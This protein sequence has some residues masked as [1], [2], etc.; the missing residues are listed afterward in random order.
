MGGY[1]GGYPALQIKP[2]ES[3]VQQLG[4]IMQLRNM[5]GQQQLQQQQIQSAQTQ[6]QSQQLDLQMKQLALKNMQTTQTALSDP[7][8]ADDFGK[9]NQSKGSPE[10]MTPAATAPGAA[11]SSGM[12]VEL[13]PIAQFLM[14]KKGLPLFGPGGAMEISNNLT[15]AA[16]DVAT[17]VKTKGDIATTQLSNYGKQLDNLTDRAEPV[18]STE[19]PAQQQAALNVFKQQVKMAPL[20]FP[21]ELVKRI[22][23]IKT[24]ADLAPMVNYGKMH[25][26]IIKEGTAQAEE[27]TAKANAVQKT[28][29]ASGIMDKTGAYT[30][31]AKS[32]MDTVNNYAAI[33]APL[34]TGLVKQMQN[35]PDMETLQKI[36]AWANSAQESFQRSADSLN[37][38]RAMKDVSVG[39]AMATE[40]IKQ[41]QTLQT[42]LQ[43]SANIRGQLDMSQGGNQQATQ[44]A[45]ISFAGHELRAGGVNRITQPEINTLGK[46]TGSWVRQIQAWEAK[47]SQG[48]M[49]TATVKN[50][51]DVLDF[52]DKLAAQQHEAN[53][54]IIQ[55]RFSGIAGGGI[56]PQTVQPSARDFGPA[57][58]KPEGAT[59]TL[60][61][62]KVVVKNGRI[63]AQ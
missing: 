6:N 4:Q 48:K 61:G 36:Q 10:G 60:N 19:D 16:Q 30:P 13:H 12:G 17:L 3:P 50:I 55:N 24:A 49:P 25:E 31:Q 45:M 5:Q 47:G 63:V 32:A 37:Q 8:M 23:D 39:Q 27:A 9:W 22:D 28:Q 44:D 43:Q 34:R 1:V 11:D 2:P 54:G 7:H 59:G 35:A 15:K 14:E 21:P 26:A 18:F 42:S 29:Q 58:G 53:V 57:A 38:A 20:E 52:E 62:T 33:P 51:Q 40:L 41:D 46:D 56:K